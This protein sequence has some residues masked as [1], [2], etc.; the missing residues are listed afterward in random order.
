LTLY[1]Q[2]SL[3]LPARVR[4]YNSGPGYATHSTREAMKVLHIVLSN[5]FTESPLPPP[6]LPTSVWLGA[7]FFLCSREDSSDHIYYVWKASEYMYF[8]QHVPSSFM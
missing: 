3:F 6:P 2:H 8:K 5:S 1:Q 4:F 7:V